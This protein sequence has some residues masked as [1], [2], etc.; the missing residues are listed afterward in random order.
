M[1]N[2]LKPK[3]VHVVAGTA[4]EF[5]EI[6]RK[7]QLEYYDTPQTEVFP[8]YVYVS[9]VDMLRGLGNIEGFYYGTYWA[10][11]DIDDIKFV[12]EMIKARQNID[13]IY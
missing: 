10:R 5:K 13:G 4:N 11:D 1:A 7:K 2:P 3:V 8:K 12:I 9:S 6:H